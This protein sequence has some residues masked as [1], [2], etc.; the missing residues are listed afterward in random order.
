MERV[1]YRR[2]FPHNQSN[3]IKTNTHKRKSQ[4]ASALRL[5]IPCIKSGGAMHRCGALQGFTLL[6]P[7]SVP[8]HRFSVCRVCSVMSQVDFRTAE[9]V[10]PRPWSFSGWQSESSHIPG[11]FPVSRVCSA[12]SRV[13]FRSAE[14]VP[15]R[16]GSI[17]GWQSA[18]C[19]VLGLIYICILIY[20]TCEKFCVPD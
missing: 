11:R 10:P 14:C 17:S 18:F 9:C 6:S 1:V 5:Y 19:R 2:I 16:P 12:T 15:P 4:G 13:D 7:R 8:C 20:T 3:F